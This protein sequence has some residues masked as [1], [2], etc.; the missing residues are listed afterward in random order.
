VVL[1]GASAVCGANLGS[2]DEGVAAV[3]SGNWV[4]ED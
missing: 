4:D 2:E 3:E 1:E